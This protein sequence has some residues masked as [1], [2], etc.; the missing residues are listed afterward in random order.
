MPFDSLGKMV[1]LLGLA[2]ALVGAGIMLVGRLPFLGNLPGD[3]SFGRDGF[4]VYLPIATSIVI[5]IVLTIVVNVALG[6]FGRR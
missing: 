5:S 6:V 1:L 2:L 4:K 3:L